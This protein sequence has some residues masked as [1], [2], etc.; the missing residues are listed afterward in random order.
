MTFTITPVEPRAIMQKLSSLLLLTLFPTL[1]LAS[2]VSAQTPAP[3]TPK[4]PGEA[5]SLKAIVIKGSAKP[6]SDITA[7]L[8]FKIEEGYHVQAN[9]ASEP[10]YI[11]AVLTL[12][13]AQGVLA[14]P[15]KYPAGK[16]EKQAGL[17]KPLLVYDG[18][19][20]IMVPMKLDADAKLPLT[21]SGVLSYQACKGAVCYPPRRLKVA[22]DI[23]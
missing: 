10:S 6:G 14:L 12:T 15:A 11:P 2:L 19:F 7:V 9:P 5:V 20:E 8:Q 22:V 18:S 3:A 23:K 1:V 21:V 17:D 13:P 16:E 4:K